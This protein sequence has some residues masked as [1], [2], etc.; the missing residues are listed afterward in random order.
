[1]KKQLSKTRFICLGFILIIL[2]GTL[3]LMLPISSRIGTFTSFFD[4][5]FTALSA[6]C[7]TGLLVV[8]TY[9]HW[10][11]FGQVVIMLLIQIG[12]MGFITIG[13]TFSV[14][15]RDKISLKAKGLMQESV[16]CTRMSEIAK[17]SKKILIGTLLF[18]GIGAIILGIRFSFDYGTKKGLFYGL[19]HSISA[20]CNGG[21]DLMGINEQYSSL[22]RY[23]ADPVVNITAFCL[24]LIGGIGFVVWDD[25]SINKLHFKKYKLHTKVVLITTAFIVISG[26]VLFYITEY[27]NTLKD[28]SASGKFYASLFSSGVSRTSGFNTIDSASLTGATKTLTI[29]QMFIG[30]SPGSTAGGIKTTTIFILFVSLWAE[31]NGRSKTSIFKRRFKD[32]AIKYASTVFTL[33][34][35]VAILAIFI[36]LGITNLPL[37]DVTFEVVSAIS[38]NGLSTGITRSLDSISKI[39]IM[40]L[41]FTG[42]VG[43]L[44][45]ALTMFEDKKDPP[46]YFPAEDISVG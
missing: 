43:S 38:T 32:N 41:M 1:M 40:L 7:V 33:N 24:A 30:G 6:T 17:L 37:E 35:F 27:N 10:S 19:F 39:I 2:I 44:S 12:G 5:A 46:V 29:I 16:S 45:F 23:V 25:I 36:I 21:M 22:T 31:M 28:L 4:S 15:L 8:D 34:L 14:L 26:T 18:E 3:L 20:F 13:V 9:T 42:R 11:T